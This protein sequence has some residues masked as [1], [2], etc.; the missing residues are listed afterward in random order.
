[1]TLPP[2]LPGLD[3]GVRFPG[4]KHPDGAVQERHRRDGEQ[5]S[6]DARHTA[7]AAMASTTANGWI[8]DRPAHHQRLQHVALQLLHGDDEAEGDQRIDE[9]LGQQCDDDGEEPGDDRADQRDERAEEDQRR[10]R[11]RQRHAHDRQAGADADRVDK[12]NQ[13]CR[14]HVAD[15][16]LKS[17]PARVAHPLLD[18]IGEDPVT[19]SRC[20]ARRGGRR[21]G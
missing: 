1:M 2:R 21:S 16:R 12:G 6:D 8:D 14:P 3:L 11:Q 10:Q 20:C 18:V 9:A 19:N 15:Q 17:G 4:G 13:E 7:P 5:R